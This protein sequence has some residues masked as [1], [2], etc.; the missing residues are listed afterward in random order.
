MTELEMEDLLC[1]HPE[2]F[3]SESLKPFG[4]QLSSSVSRADLVF[5]DS[6]NRLLVVELKKGTFPR[7]GVSQLLDHLGGVK[8]KYPGRD[9]EGVAVANR[10]PAERKDT[11]ARYD[12]DWLEIPDRHFREVAAEK[13][14]IFQSERILPQTGVRIPATTTNPVRSFRNSSALHIFRTEKVVPVWR[15]KRGAAMAIIDAY[16]ADPAH[17]NGTLTVKTWL[18]LVA[19]AGITKVSFDFARFYERN[20][21][22]NLSV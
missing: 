22:I 21:L 3:F 13:G 12:I 18:A 4:R 17:L 8:N 11:L 10:I 19:D 6:L 15:G 1:D 16:Y 14:Y 2:F 20:G 9:V 5:V 7:Q